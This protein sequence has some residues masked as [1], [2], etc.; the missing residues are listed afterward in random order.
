MLNVKNE[1]K[2]AE[3]R[4]LT[5]EES[6]DADSPKPLKLQGLS[7]LNANGRKRISLREKVLTTAAGAAAA[8][9]GMIPGVRRKVSRVAPALVIISTALLLTY[10]N[11][12]MEMLF[13]ALG[14]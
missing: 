5:A 12:L 13:K 6:A 11:I 3:I 10:G 7:V 9:A 1:N 4:V 2:T 8:A 14:I